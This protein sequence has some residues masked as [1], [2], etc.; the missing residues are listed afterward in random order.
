VASDA[1]ND[2]TSAQADD[3]YRKDWVTQNFLGGPN[4]KNP[5]GHI[6]G[7]DDAY[8]IGC[9]MLF[10]YYLKDQLGYSMPAIVQNGAATLDGTYRLLTNGRNDGFSAFVALIRKY[11]PNYKP[12]L[13]D[14]PFPLF[15]LDISVSHWHTDGCGM[16]YQLVGDTITIKAS[17]NDFPTAIPR[18][19]T[20]FLWV[21]PKNVQLVSTNDT[22][23]LIISL[24]SEGLVNLTVHVMVETASKKVPKQASIQ[25]MVLTLS[26]DAIYVGL[27]KLGHM[28]FIPQPIPIGDPAYLVRNPAAASRIHSL[29]DTELKELRSSLIENSREV[30]KLQGLVANVI[31]ERSQK[32]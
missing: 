23:S 26:E 4:K 12:C 7:D 19:K 11:F 9:A 29:S 5:P 15:D 8:S 22:D 30:E 18:T 20:T 14:D 28:R 27:C 13:T 17:V 2:P 32:H 6:K 25:F 10:I 21:V 24:N 3:T 1:P 16:Y 31:K